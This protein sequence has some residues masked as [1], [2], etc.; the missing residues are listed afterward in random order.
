M[1]PTLSV[2]LITE[3][4]ISSCEVLPKKNIQ[5]N[6]VE[7]AVVQVVLVFNEQLIVGVVL[8]N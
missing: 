3:C 5:E 8:T 4:I 2:A 6:V 7:I 1:P